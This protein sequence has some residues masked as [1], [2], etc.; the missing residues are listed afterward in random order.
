MSDKY[1][2]H[3]RSNGNIVNM[4]TFLN[5]LDDSIMACWLK[6]NGFSGGSLPAQP[7]VIGHETTPSP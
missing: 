4:T 5:Y 6:A 1:N 2:Y 7:P 3:T